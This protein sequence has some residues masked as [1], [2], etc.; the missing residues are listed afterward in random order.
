MNLEVLLLIGFL[1][2]G[3]IIRY[4]IKN[5]VPAYF[6]EKGKN[7]A[8][9]Q[10]IEDITQKIESVKAKINVASQSEI[11]LTAQRY[12]ALIALH[13]NYWLWLSTIIHPPLEADIKDVEQDLQRNIRE[14]R[15]AYQQ[16]VAA[17]A[18]VRIFLFR[19][20]RLLDVIS[21]L[22]RETYLVSQKQIGHLSSMA[23]AAKDVAQQELG[24]TTSQDQEQLFAYREAF[25]QLVDECAKDISNRLNQFTEK[26]NGFEALVNQHVI[27]LMSS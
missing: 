17:E 16:F 27:S 6:T 21:G 8:T 9:K 18:L 11:A 14:L 24:I 25:S 15:Q 2:L 1:A 3:F 26:R 22:K 7:L 19:E 5:T 23:F 10:D 4:L 20:P 13:T 12:N